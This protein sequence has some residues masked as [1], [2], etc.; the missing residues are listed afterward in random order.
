MKNMNNELLVYSFQ[1]ERHFNQLSFLCR[2]KSASK[3]SGL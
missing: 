2:K 1:Q 3:P